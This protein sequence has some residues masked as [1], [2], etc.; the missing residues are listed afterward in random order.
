[1]NAT[2]TFDIE[3]ALARCAVMLAH[4]NRTDKGVVATI[5][6]V[7]RLESRHREDGSADQADKI[8]RLLKWFDDGGPEPTE[9]LEFSET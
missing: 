7:R 2:N 3:L 9:K 5:W 8:A 6:Q 1:M 4:R